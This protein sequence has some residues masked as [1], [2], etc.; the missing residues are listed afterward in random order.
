[1][2]LDIRVKMCAHLAREQEHSSSPKHKARIENTQRE[3]LATDT[4]IVSKNL[5]GTT[6]DTK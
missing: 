3:I 2:S 1:M 6:K 4:G 5:Y